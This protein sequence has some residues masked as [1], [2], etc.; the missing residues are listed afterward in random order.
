[1]QPMTVGILHS[2]VWAALRYDG[3]WRWLA[4]GVNWPMTL[5]GAKVRTHSGGA[6]IFSTYP[7]AVLFSIFVKEVDKRRSFAVSQFRNVLGAWR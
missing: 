5:T 1:M 7:P 2:L 3:P 6:Y 4:H